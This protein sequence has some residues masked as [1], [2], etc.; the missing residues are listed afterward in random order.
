M[1]DQITFIKEVRWNKCIPFPFFWI[2][3]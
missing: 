1:F 2:L 3:A